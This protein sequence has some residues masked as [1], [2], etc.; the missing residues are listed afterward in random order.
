MRNAVDSKQLQRVY[1]RAASHYDFQHALLTFRSD[2]RGRHL[3]AEHGVHK[4]DQVLDCGAGTGSSSFLAAAKAGK[5]GHITLFDM[6]EGMLE[7]ARN[8]ARSMGY[9]GRVDFRTGDILALPFVDNS[10]DCVISTYSICPLYDPAKGA[11]EMWRVVKPGGRLAV[12][13][14][15]EPR[16]RFSKWLGDHV[17]NIAWHFPWLTLGCRAVEVL[18]VLKNAGG[19]VTFERY[20]GFP[21]WPFVVFVVEKP[22]RT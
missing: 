21:L 11:L 14:S 18:S 22:E 5:S 2:E 16:S 1:D 7:E 4:G 12:A 17:E 10:F 15:V 13:H 19:T 9:D 6:S 8:K 20:L 3:V